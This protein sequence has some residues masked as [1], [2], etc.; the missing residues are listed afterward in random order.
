MDREVEPVTK[1]TG[2]VLAIPLS[3]L[4]AH[5]DKKDLKCAIQTDPDGRNLQTGYSV[6]NS[7]CKLEKRKKRYK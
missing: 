6:F 7:M 3:S 2:V 4:M 1:G 5:T